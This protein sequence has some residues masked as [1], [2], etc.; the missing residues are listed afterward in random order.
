M[1][2]EDQVISFEMAH[3]LVHLGMRYTG[4]YHW[5]ICDDCTKEYGDE[6]IELQDHPSHRTYPALTATELFHL[7]PPLIT[8]PLQKPSLAFRL[9]IEKPTG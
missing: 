7:L 3:K 6:K 8:L 9:T 5:N 4:L 2:L 1:K